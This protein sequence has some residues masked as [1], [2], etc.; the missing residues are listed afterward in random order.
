[1]WIYLLSFLSMIISTHS[2][3]CNLVLPPFPLSYNGLITPYIVKGATPADRCLQENP[4]TTSF[5][6]ATIFNPDNGHISVYHPL[7]VNDGTTPLVQPT[8]FVLPNNAIISISFGTNANTLRLIPPTSVLAGR[9]VNG[10]STTDIFGQFSYCNSDS[11]FDRVNEWIASG[12]EL[13]PPIPPLGIA[14]DGLECLTTRHFMLVDQDPSDNLVTTYLLDPITMR[15]SQDTVTN[16]QIYPAAAILKN[17]SDNRLLTLLNLAMGCKGYVAPL[18]SDPSGVM[19]ASMVLNE[20]HAAARQEAPMV[21]L[22]SRDPMTRVLAGGNTIPSL[23][24]NNLYRKGINQKPITTIQQSDTAPFCGYLGNMIS[25]LQSNKASFTS[26]VSPDP[27]AASNLFTFLATRFSQTHVNL[28]C[29]I[30][31]DQG[32]PVVLTLTGGI[33]T[34][35]VFTALPFYQFLGQ[36]PYVPIP[37]TIPPTPTSI[38]PTTPPIPPTN[39]PVP[40]I[41]YTPGIEVLGIVCGSIVAIAII[42]WCIYK[43]KN[44]SNNIPNNNPNNN[45]PNNNLNNNNNPVEVVPFI[46]SPR[47]PRSNRYSPVYKP[48]G[49]R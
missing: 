14:N 13:V 2:A 44:V 35:A 32:N 24:K 49:A 16:R 9:C 39:P 38:P 23:L 3:D 41:S 11:L 4:A 21:S 27:A 34:D 26:Q 36:D 33:T 5:V 47:S 18:L 22:P 25:R 19:I 12:K 1:M 31:L 8:P 30:L 46:N 15:V 42:V 45:I 20:L 6:E 37:P 7:V 48:K 10:I 29:D 28:K 17:G 43:N 40:P